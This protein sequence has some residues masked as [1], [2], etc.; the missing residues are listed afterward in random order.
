[1]TEN[2]AKLICRHRKFGTHVLTVNASAIKDAEAG[3]GVVVQ[4]ARD[5]TG[6]LVANEVLDLKRVQD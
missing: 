6:M 1:M 2:L 4:T 5:E 3:T